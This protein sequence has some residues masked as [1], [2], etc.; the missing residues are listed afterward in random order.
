MDD[1]TILISMIILAEAVRGPVPLKSF[2]RVQSFLLSV[3]YPPKCVGG[4][5]GWCCLCELITSLYR[6]DMARH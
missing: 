5:C 3:Q 2:I 1:H 4:D 6:R